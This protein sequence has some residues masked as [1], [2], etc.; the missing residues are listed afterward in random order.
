MTAIVVLHY[1]RIALTAECCKTLVAQ[2]EPARYS[3][4]KKDS[5]C[6]AISAQE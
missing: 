2:T 4:S 5:N 1:E 6:A 3:E